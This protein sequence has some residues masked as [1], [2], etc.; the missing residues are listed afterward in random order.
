VK[1]L[2]N[3]VVLSATWLL[4]VALLPMAW[5][6]G[7]IYGPSLPKPEDTEKEVSKPSKKDDP[8]QKKRRSYFPW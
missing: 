5:D 7:H 1:Y 3:G 8:P 2:G 6:A 4:P